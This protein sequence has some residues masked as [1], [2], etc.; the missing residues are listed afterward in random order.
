MIRVPTRVVIEQSLESVPAI[1]ELIETGHP[2]FDFTLC[3]R[4]KMSTGTKAGIIVLETG[5]SQRAT[6]R[7]MRAMLRGR[8]NPKVLLVGPTISSDFSEEA[9]V[10]GASG[11]FDDRASA[12]M[13]LKGLCCVERGELWLG[14]QRTG[15]VFDRL[16]RG[17]IRKGKRHGRDEERC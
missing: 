1:Q 4:S 6:L 15:R 10:R 9:I 8:H 11:L 14:R 17:I 16:S 3:E 5:R 12:L 2:G 13:M 7:L